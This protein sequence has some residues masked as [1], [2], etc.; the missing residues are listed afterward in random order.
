[1]ERTRYTRFALMPSIAL[2]L[3]AMGCRT[4]V[5]GDYELDLEETKKAVVKS[6]AEN[7]EDAPM[8]DA[9]LKMYSAMRLLVTLHEDGKMTSRTSLAMPDAPPG[10]GRQDG[11]WKLDQGRVVISVTDGDTVC[12]VDA[13]RLR[14][15]REA[16][17]KL[18]GSYVLRRK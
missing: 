5:A 16:Y 18:Q 11:T 4:K 15:A 1:M 3:L 13:Q 9:T 7:P 17:N 14:C 6:A 10:E 12:Q 8:K 2:A